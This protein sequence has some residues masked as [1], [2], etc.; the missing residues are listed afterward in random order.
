MKNLAIEMR[1][2]HRDRIRAKV[3]DS[4]ET[5]VYIDVRNEVRFA[6][7]GILFEIGSVLLNRIKEF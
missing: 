5:I 6:V 1:Y 7:E 4:I 3:F 2:R